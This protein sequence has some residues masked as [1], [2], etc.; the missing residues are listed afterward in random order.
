M[1]SHGE[2][3]AGQAATWSSGLRLVDVPAPVV[4]AARNCILDL[5][6]VSLAGAH[7]SARTGLTRTKNPSDT[8]AHRNI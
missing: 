3:L 8:T 6:G 1:A 2:T 7:E 5:S 4:D